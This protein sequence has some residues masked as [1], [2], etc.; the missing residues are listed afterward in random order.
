[1]KLARI[2]NKYQRKYD[3]QQESYYEEDDGGFDPRWGCEF[4]RFCR[5][6]GMR[7]PSIEDCLGCSDIAGS[8][9]RSYSRSNRL[10]QIRVPVHQRL[11]PLNQDHDQD[12]DEGRKTQWCPS[13]IFTKNQ[14]R[15][16]QRLRNREC[17]QEV[18]QEIN[19]RLKKAKPR[20]EWR[21][22][23]QVATADEVE[24]DKAK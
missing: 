11:G 4:F 14:K 15:R 7:L 23:S 13:G 22:K 20:Q 18:E 21:V 17:F 8:L 12:E 1:M 19:H 3:K 2:I 10:R 6:E 24:A 9:S 5:N 16:V